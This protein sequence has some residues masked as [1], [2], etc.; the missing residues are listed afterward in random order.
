MAD[1]GEQYRQ[2]FSSLGRPLR[3]QDGIPEKELLAAEKQLGLR[4]PAALRDYYRIAG[5]AD[6]FNCAHDELLPPTSWTIESR[7]LVFMVENQSVLSYALPVGPQPVGD[8]PPVFW[9]Q[10]DEPIRWYKAIGRCTDFLMVMLHVQAAFCGAMPYHNTAQVRPGLRKVLDRD[11]SF[12]GE[13]HSMRAYHKPGRVVCFVKDWNGSGRVFVGVS[14]EADLAAVAHELSLLWEDPPHPA[15]DAKGVK[16]SYSVQGEGEAVLLIHGLF[17]SSVLEWAVAG[18]TDLL[19]E[20]YRVIALDLPGHGISD[21]PTKETAYGLELVEDVVRIM[22]HLK[23]SKVHIVASCL[24]SIIA[25]K[26][27]A[28]HPDRVLSAALGGM[29]WL[30]HGGFA[31]N[32]FQNFRQTAS[33]AIVACARTLGKLTL[34]KKEVEAIRIPVIILVGECDEVVKKRYIEPLRIVRRD[35]RVINIRRADHLNCPAKPQSKEEIAKW[36]AK[37]VQR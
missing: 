4:V 30:R 13:L 5:R 17:S 24:G 7:R 16:I 37:Q 11:W 27:I 1:F 33:K 18:T 23:V 20:N 2:A 28:K 8:N 32:V 9:G 26:L 10:D 6:D 25:A 35:W 29:G 36:L 31:H 34:S 14:R 15:F 22:D 3:R 12:V 21:K 19:A